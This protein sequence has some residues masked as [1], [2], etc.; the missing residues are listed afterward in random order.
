MGATRAVVDAGIAGNDLQI[1]QTGKHVTPDLYFAFGISGA[2][3]HLAG[4]KEAKCIVAINS[5]ADAPIFRHAHYGLLGDAT[6]A[7]TQIADKLLL[8]KEDAKSA[9]NKSAQAI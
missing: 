4:M 1:G 7:I 3:Q 2:I 8:M 5:D 9:V 6:A